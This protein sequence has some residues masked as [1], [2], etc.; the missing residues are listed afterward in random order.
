[1]KLPKSG[2]LAL[3]SEIRLFKDDPAKLRQPRNLVDAILKPMR[4]AGEGYRCALT[5]LV[6]TD[7][8][9]EVL[10][11]PYIPARCA[12]ILPFALRRFDEQ[13]A[14]ETENK[15]TIWWALYRYFPDL[16]GLIGPESINQHQNALTMYMPHHFEFGQFNLA[17]RWLEPALI[18][19]H[20]ARRNVGV[21]VLRDNG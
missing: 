8:K 21:Y 9:D 2:Q 4:A 11:G 5:G 16:K 6:D 13:S 1:M 15:A 14:Q 19:L 12:H 20:T 7:S 17:F 10:A 3:T 18:C